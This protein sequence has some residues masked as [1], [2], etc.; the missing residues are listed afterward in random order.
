MNQTGQ[1]DQACQMNQTGH[2]GQVDQACQADQADQA[3]Q[4]NQ[5]G[6]DLLVLYVLQVLFEA[7]HGPRWVSGNR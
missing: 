1:A 4:M 7:P 3:C 5:T 2:T 6:Q